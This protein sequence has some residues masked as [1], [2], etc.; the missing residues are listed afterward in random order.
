MMFADYVYVQFDRNSRKKVAA[1]QND[2]NV[3]R[4]LLDSITKQAPLQ[5]MIGQ[6]NNRR[7][8]GGSNGSTD[9]ANVNKTWP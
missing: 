2:G 1:V 7:N 4:T 9:G 8:D 5:E 6:H 3:L